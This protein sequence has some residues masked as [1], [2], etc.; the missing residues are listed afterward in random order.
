[1]IGKLFRFV[2]SIVLAGQV[3]AAGVPT[4]LALFV[5]GGVVWVIR[6]VV[7]DWYRMRA[8]ARRDR[9]RL[10]RQARGW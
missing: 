2:C 9:R 6:R 5:G 8:D 3:H 4:L 1:M 10:L 7:S